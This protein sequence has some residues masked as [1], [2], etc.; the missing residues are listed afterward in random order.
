VALTLKRPKQVEVTMSRA[1]RV[2]LG[3]VLGAVIAAMCWLTLPPALAAALDASQLP[4][5]PDG[6]R[7]VSMQEQDKLVQSGQGDQY[8][9]IVRHN[10]EL[11]DRALTKMTKPELEDL[12]AKMKEL[13]ANPPSGEVQNY[14]MTV[15]VKASEH[16]R[17]RKSRPS[18]T[19]DALVAAQE[20]TTRGFPNDPKAVAAEA[21]RIEELLTKQPKEELY[22]AIL[23]PLRIRPW[24]ADARRVL[25]EIVALD[26]PMGPDDRKT[27][28]TL[29]VAA[30][31]FV[32][33]RQKEEPEQGSWLSLEA[34]LR[35][36]GGESNEPALRETAPLWERAIAL[37]PKDDDSFAMDVI[38]ARLAGDAGRESAAIAR[39]EAAGAKPEAI[40]D[41]VKRHGEPWLPDAEKTRL[42]D[43]EKR[44]PEGATD[45]Q[46]RLVAVSGMHDPF[47]VIKECEEV[48][49]L[50]QE[51]LP[52]SY[53]AGFLSVSLETRALYS[54]DCDAIAAQIQPLEA[55]A[56]AAF[57]PAE[58]SAA[59][60]KAADLVLLRRRTEELKTSLSMIDGALAKGKTPKGQDLTAGQRSDLQEMRKVL[61]QQIQESLTLLAG[62]QANA[63][64]VGSREL[65]PMTRAEAH[66]FPVRAAVARCFMRMRRP[67]DGVAVLN[68]CYELRAD[69]P[70]DLIA[71]QLDETFVELGHIQE[72]ADF[73]RRLE[74]AGVNA[75]NLGSLKEAINRASPGEIP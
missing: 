38:L 18:S 9:A 52:P 1:R 51:V 65:L 54:E 23:K 37:R 66:V 5:V 10:F 47:K 2:R 67:S 53:R 17:L 4:W 48:L 14:A 22:L 46:S 69:N 49:R 60:H 25:D 30:L 35:S 36:R 28:L 56:V 19:F 43:I 70:C 34:R 6:W 68:R 13:L 61:D 7:F 39:Y 16:L 21:E 71:T 64:K 57:P 73:Y 41:Y 3:M 55:L 20:E 8:A 40:E 75:E 33:E 44:R 59:P 45:W 12:I 62:P 50:P 63:V 27:F 32:Q 74:V 26:D 31:R 72:A 42:Y 29:R 11:M 24:N 58:D 15:S